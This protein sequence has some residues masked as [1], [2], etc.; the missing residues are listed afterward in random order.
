MTHEFLGGAVVAA[1][2]AAL[3]AAMAWRFWRMPPTPSSTRV[4]F[5]LIGVAAGALTGPAAAAALIATNRKAGYDVAT[6]A[7][8]AT[9]ALIGG[10]IGQHFG[11][12]A[13][14]PR[15]RPAQE[16]GDY[17]DVSDDPSRQ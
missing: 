11:K 6:P 13:G 1:I 8:A 16:Q 4:A 3:A 2:M 14:W 7:L 10:L 17:D 9:A 12:R 5:F 15:G